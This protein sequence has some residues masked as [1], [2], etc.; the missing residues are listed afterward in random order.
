MGEK[1]G[2]PYLAWDEERVRGGR[3]QRG[4]HY[5]RQEGMEKHYLNETQ[6]NLTEVIVAMAP[7]QK[8]KGG[9]GDEPDE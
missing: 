8:G 5:R 6:W 1:E 3:K 2:K 7:C 4:Q 9:L